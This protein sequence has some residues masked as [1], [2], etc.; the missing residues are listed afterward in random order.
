MSDSLVTIA[1]FWSPVEADLARN[2]LEAAGIQAFLANAVTVG[3]Y[4]HLSNAVGGVRLQVR[5]GDAEEALAVLAEQPAAA[6][7]EESEP[8]LTS[9]EQNADRAF[10]GA[11]L[12]LLFL[13]LQLYVFW[14][15]LKVFISDEHLD[16]GKR[17]NAIVAAI[18]NLPLM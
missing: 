15:L 3:M 14:L 2:R 16:P 8:V 9:R 18:I 1:A 11:V 4:W 10:R 12:G 17:R 6:E 13:P 7:A 5:E